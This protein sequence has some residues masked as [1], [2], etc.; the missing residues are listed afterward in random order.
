MV[1]VE[2]DLRHR[3]LAPGVDLAVEAIELELEV[4]GRRV[5]GDAE[6]NEVGASIGRPL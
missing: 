2:D 5:H 1:E 4:V 3:E 6:K